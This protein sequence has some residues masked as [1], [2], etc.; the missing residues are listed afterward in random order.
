MNS[1]ITRAEHLEFSKRME[2]EHARQNRRIG[3]L[4]KSVEKNNELL[5]SVERLAVSIENMQKEQQAQGKRLEVLGDEID[6]L[7]GRD[8]EMWRKAIGYV[9]TSVISIFIGYIFTQLGM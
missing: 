9:I 6:E 1:P 3:D 7:K 5:V 2:E 8:G 4:E